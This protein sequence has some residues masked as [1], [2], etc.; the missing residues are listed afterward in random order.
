MWYNLFSSAR[1]DELY[2]RSKGATCLTAIYRGGTGRL[3][4]ETA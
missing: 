2:S 1:E 4:S 3:R